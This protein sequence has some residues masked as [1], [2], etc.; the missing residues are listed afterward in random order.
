MEQ[1]FL[2][3]I[4]ATSCVDAPATVF[5]P[6]FSDGLRSLNPLEIELVNQMQVQEQNRFTLDRPAGDEFEEVA[7]YSSIPYFEAFDGSTAHIYLEM[8]FKTRDL[9]NR[10]L[11]NSSGETKLHYE[12]MLY[13]I[14]KALKKN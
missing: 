9:I 11:V 6:Q 3:S 4:I 7:G 13:R 14:K 10:A 12:L 2:A 5:A 8:L 1:L